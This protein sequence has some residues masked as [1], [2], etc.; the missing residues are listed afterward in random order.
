MNQEEVWKD[1]KN[2]EGLYQVSNRGRVRRLKI[3][4]DKSRIEVK[5]NLL[6]RFYYKLYK[7]GI[8]TGYSAKKLVAITFMGYTP[9]H[10]DKILFKD[11]NPRNCTPSNIKIVR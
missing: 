3:T 11:N 10:G 9:L 6:H 1:V 5:N 8:E 7:N 4:F 2:Y